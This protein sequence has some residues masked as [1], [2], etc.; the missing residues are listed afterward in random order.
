MHT[1][2]TILIVEDDPCIAALIADAL[3]DETPA[4]I[5]TLHSGSDAIR[6]L[7]TDRVDLAILDYHLPGATGIEVYDAM[8]RDPCT[9]TTPV[10]FITANDRRA[11]FDQRGLTY[12]RKPFN[13]FELLATVAARLDERHAHSAS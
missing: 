3:A 5:R 13:L 2:P 6:L 7:A 1:Q 4:R 12:I 11:E 9:A 8:R 10:L